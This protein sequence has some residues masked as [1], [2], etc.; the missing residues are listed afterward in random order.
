MLE[1]ITKELTVTSNDDHIMNGGVLALAK[2]V[3]VQR[4]QAAVLDTL[5][6]V[7]QFDKVKN[8]KKTKRR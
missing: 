3:E 8:S 1:E 5:T 2:R 7:R 4:A 6:D